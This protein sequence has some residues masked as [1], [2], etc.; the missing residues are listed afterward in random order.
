MNEEKAVAEGFRFACLGT[1]GFAA[2][3]FI[4]FHSFNSLARGISADG[5]S[6][7]LTSLLRSA[8]QPLAKLLDAAVAGEKAVRFLGGGAGRLRFP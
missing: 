8:L 5:V 4:R 2:N 6:V 1:Q 3:A 7:W